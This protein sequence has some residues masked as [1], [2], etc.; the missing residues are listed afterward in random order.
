MYS[1]ETEIYAQAFNVS[2]AFG[3]LLLLFTSKHITARKEKENIC[4]SQY[5]RLTV[6]F[7]MTISTK[8]T[9]PPQ[10]SF[11]RSY[12]IFS[13]FLFTPIVMM[14]QLFFLRYCYSSISL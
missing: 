11:L 7:D 12:A 9:M 8:Q 13:S 2:N 4:F 3:S 10:I 6:L 5:T 1:F 14:S